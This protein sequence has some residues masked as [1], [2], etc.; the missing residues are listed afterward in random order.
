M[1][2][3]NCG[4][5]WTVG[6]NFSFSESKCPFCGKALSPE[7]KLFET[8]EDV[9]VEIRNSYGLEVLNDGR[10]LLAYFADLAPQFRKQKRILGDFIEINGP[11]KIC[12][13][14]NSNSYDEQKACIKRIVTEMKEEMLL[15]EAACRMICESFFYAV[16][17]RHVDIDGG[18]TARFGMRGENADNRKIEVLYATQNLSP[19]EQYHKGNEFGKAGDFRQA[20]EW[21]RKAAEKGNASAQCNLGFCYE[22]GIGIG[23]DKK[24]AVRWY[25]K[26]AEQGSAV[27]QSN[28]GLCYTKGYGVEKSEEEAICW[29]RKSAEQGN[30]A[31]QFFLS[32]CYRRGSGIKEDKEEALRWWNKAYEHWK[33]KNGNLIS[34]YLGFC[35]ENEAGSKEDEE[36]AVCWYRKAAEQGSAWMQYRLGSCYFTGKGVEKDEEEAVRWYRKAA[37][38]GD[39]LAQYDLGSCYSNGYGIKENKEEAV[40]WYREAAEQGMAAAQSVLGFYYENGIGV[41][42]DKEEAVCWYRKAAKQ[43]NASAQNSL[44][45]CYENGIGIEEDKKKQYAGTERRQS[46]GMHLHK[47]I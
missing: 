33:H 2:C 19:E 1:R 4:S 36:G 45:I 9:L 15:D 27:A 17:G 22:N 47:I 39:L 20:V 34:Q 25:R 14:Q 41:K 30:V 6:S 16:T 28:L 18:E 12:A 13:V 46:R 29:Y 31:A 7:K 38:Q 10:K 21:Y 5:E 24:E 26:A 44:G 35:Y 43:G 32:S 37:E 3:N 42:E 40:C 23:E 11:E 8:V